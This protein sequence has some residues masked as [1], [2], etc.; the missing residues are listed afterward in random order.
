ME[1]ST[2]ISSDSFVENLEKPKMT[3][4]VQYAAILTYA[5]DRLPDNSNFRLRIEEIS[6]VKPDPSIIFSAL[7]KS[8]LE[9]NFDIDFILSAA[10]SPI[11]TMENFM[12]P[13]YYLFLDFYPSESFRTDC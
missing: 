10:T 4:A 9:Q 11:P 1:I 7:E 3:W 8:G 5:E 6:D 12:L 2:V 13:I